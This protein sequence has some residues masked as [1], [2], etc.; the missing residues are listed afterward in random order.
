MKCGSVKQ[1]VEILQEQLNVQCVVKV[2]DGSRME[3]AI[4]ESG[5]IILTTNSDCVELINSRAGV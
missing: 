3:Y 1:Y 5:E 2:S 4:S